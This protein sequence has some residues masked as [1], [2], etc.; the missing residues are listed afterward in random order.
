MAIPAAQGIAT[1]QRKGR[2]KCLRKRVFLTRR[3]IDVKDAQIFR[4]SVALANSFL[5]SAIVS[6]CRGYLY[7]SLPGINSDLASEFC[8]VYLQ[9][10]PLER[11][12]VHTRSALFSLSAALICFADH[13]VSL[14]SADT[15]VQ[16]TH[17]HTGCRVADDT[18]PV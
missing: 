18:S 15:H 16:K 13:Y 9:S 4:M 6:C 11:V 5:F 12:V 3:V 10:L 8:P 2:V 17:T 14:P 1:I 7:I